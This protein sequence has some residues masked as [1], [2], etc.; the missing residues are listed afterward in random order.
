MADDI[1]KIK[2]TN[3]VVVAAMRNSIF[4]ANWRTGEEAIIEK[5]V[6]HA[7]VVWLTPLTI[8]IFRASSTTFI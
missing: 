2:L 1:Y 6:S 7:K 8:C 3:K 4:V 5:M